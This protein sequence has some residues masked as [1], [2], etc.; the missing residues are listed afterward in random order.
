MIK[1]KEWPEHVPH[2]KKDTGAR[3]EAREASSQAAGIWGPWGPVGW[4][5]VL[6]PRDRA[7]PKAPCHGG[8]GKHWCRTPQGPKAMLV[9]ERL[10]KPGV[11]QQPEKST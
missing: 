4:S 3:A 6:R 10:E 9:S 11:Q 5:R 1:K 7:P 8:T 2:L